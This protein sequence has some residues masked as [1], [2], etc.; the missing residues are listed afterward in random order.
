MPYSLPGGERAVNCG[1]Q[2][3]HLHQLA[4]KLVH[5]NTVYTKYLAVLIDNKFFSSA[6]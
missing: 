3:C 6:N 2:N 5:N 1:Y 4:R